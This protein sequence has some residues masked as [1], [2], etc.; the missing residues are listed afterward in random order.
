MPSFL[1]KQK[2]IWKNSKNEFMKLAPEGPI[3]H[4]QL[5][6]SKALDLWKKTFHYFSCPGGMYRY[7]LRRRNRRSWVR[8]PARVQG[9]TNVYTAVLSFHDLR[10]LSEKITGVDVMITIFCYVCQFSLKKLA[11]FSKTN[12]M[13]TIFAKTSSSLS[14]KRQYFC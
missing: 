12:V 2:H 10:K 6:G 5:L 14:K 3:S 1:T 9:V 7:R 11:F 13:I 8:I 4:D